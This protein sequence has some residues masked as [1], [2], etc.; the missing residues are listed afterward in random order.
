MTDGASDISEFLQACLRRERLD[1]VT[2][3]EAA[4][5][6]DMAG[7]LTDSESRRGQPLRDMLRA[8]AITEA[9]QRPPRPQGRWFIVQRSRAS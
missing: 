7:V 1:E 6:L 2:A 4:R 3:V 9:E 5:W 8:G